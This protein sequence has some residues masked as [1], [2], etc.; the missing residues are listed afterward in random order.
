M[1]GPCQRRRRDASTPA[2]GTRG[3][4]CRSRPCRRSATNSGTEISKPVASLAFFSTLP[5]VSPL[6]AGSVSVISRTS[7]GRQLDRDRLAVVEHDLDR[8]AVLE[9]LDRVAHVLGLD[10]ELVVL[11]VHERVHRV[12]E[13]GVGALLLVEDDLVHLV[14]GLED[15]LGARVAEQALQLHAHGGRVAA[16]AAVFGLEHDH[17]VLALHDDVAGANFLGDFHGEFHDG[18][19]EARGREAT[20]AIG[21]QRSAKP[22]ILAFRRDEAEAAGSR[23]RAAPRAASRQRGAVRQPRRAQGRSG[24]GGASGRSPMP[25]QARTARAAP[26]PARAARRPGSGRGRPR[27]WR[28][29]RRRPASRSARRRARRP[30]CARTSE[31]SPRTKLRSHDQS[32]RSKSG[33]ASS[34]RRDRAQRAAAQRRRRARAAT[35]SA[36]APGGSS[37]R[38]GARGERVEQ[39]RARRRCVAEQADARARP[40]RGAMPCAASQASPRRRRAGARA[41]PARAAGRRCRA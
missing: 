4:G 18:P 13:V 10:L 15:D 28:R 9:V 22:R 14:V 5:E 34:G 2:C 36:A 41:G 20:G 35:C 24:S 7:A 27:A 23:G 21:R 31:S 11:G 25:F 39:R 16:A 32:R 8:H 19:L 3:C 30:R 29:G 40:A 37:S 6:T 12:G 26:R 1:A 38:V 17:R 33:C